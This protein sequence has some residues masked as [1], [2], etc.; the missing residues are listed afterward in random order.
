MSRWVV[1]MGL[2]LASGCAFDSSV[3]V[4][5]GGPGTVTSNPPGIDCRSDGGVCAIEVDAS[6]TLELI[7]N[8]P[9]VGAEFV[10]WSGACAG[11][12]TCLVE[13]TNDVEVG[14]VFAAA[15]RTLRISTSGRGAYLVQSEPPGIMCG[16]GPRVCAV[17]VPKNSEVVLSA[18]YDLGS[19][20]FLGW[21]GEPACGTLDTCHVVLDRDRSI[22]A[23][24]AVRLFL[25][26]GVSG[27]GSITGPNGLDCP[28]SKCRAQFAD[29]SVVTLHATPSPGARFNGWLGGGCSGVAD[30]TVTINYQTTVTAD[31]VAM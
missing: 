4:V 16:P 27:P 6:T 26:L 14:A 24:Y 5:V 31:F 8:T 10:G 11:T 18:G 9:A 12:G 20:D 22:A 29:G 2:L 7:S 21:S 28:G 17:E 25:I 19:T 1:L 23:A 15:R 13:P 3:V 30:C